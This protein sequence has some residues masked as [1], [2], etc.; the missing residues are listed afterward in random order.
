MLA[1]LIATR[2]PAP[3]PPPILFYSNQL[4]AATTT[5]LCISIA[6][7]AVTLTNN[8]LVAQNLVLSI[9]GYESN[10]DSLNRMYFLLISQRSSDEPAFLNNTI[11]QTITFVIALNNVVQSLPVDMQNLGILNVLQIRLKTALSTLQALGKP[12]SN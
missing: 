11:A 6:R 3:P 2:Q 1:A 4:V 8:R 9:P 10:I 5:F 12:I 7:R